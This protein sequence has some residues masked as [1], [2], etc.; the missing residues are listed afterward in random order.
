MGT[1]I[2]GALRSRGVEVIAGEPWNFDEWP[3]VGG[4][5]MEGLID[6][7]IDADVAAAGTVR[8]AVTALAAVDTAGG[9]MAWQ[10][11]ETVPILVVG[12]DLLVTTAA[13]EACT[14]DVGVSGDATTS[15]DTLL[16]GQDVNAAT[17]IFRATAAVRLD[18]KGGTTDYITA[19]K[20][21][22]ASAGIVGYGVVRYVKLPD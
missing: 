13:T 17:G 19:S 11:P 6:A 9:V 7:K 3:E 5:D 1:G 21:T 14:V 20:A 15:D 4:S 2:R 10:N 8:A 12:F 16:D 18:E 22:G